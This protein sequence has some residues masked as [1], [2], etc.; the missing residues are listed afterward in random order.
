MEFDTEISKGRNNYDK[1]EKKLDNYRVEEQGKIGEN[2]KNIN[3]DEKFLNKK[4][5]NGKIKKKITKNF[6][7]F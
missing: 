1:N 3:K 2:K 7:I 5:E 6:V 4:E